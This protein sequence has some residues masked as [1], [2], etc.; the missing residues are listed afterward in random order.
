ME[1]H[2]LSAEKP[3]SKEELIRTLIEN[4]G[5]SDLQEFLHPTSPLNL[6]LQDVGI[7]PKQVT[8]A[9]TRL[10][11]AKEKKE[12]IVIYG[13]YDCDGVCATTVLWETMFSLGFNVTPFI[14]ERDKHGYGLSQKGIDEILQKGKPD[15][16]ISVDNGIVAHGPWQ[17]L[18][19]LGVFTILSDHH[20]PDEKKSPAD[21]IVHTTKLCGTTVSWMLAREIE[22]VCTP[23]THTGKVDLLLDLCAIATIADQVP[24]TE[25]NRSFALFGLQQLNQTK[26]LGLQLL[27]ESS[28]LTPGEI[29]EWGVNY[30]IAPRINAMGRLQSALD[31]LRLLCTHKVERARELVNTVQDVNRTRQELTEELLQKA[32]SRANEWKDEHIIIIDD[33]DFHEGVIGLIAGK[34]TEVFFKPA[35]ALS[36]GKISSKGSARSVTGIHITNLLRTVRDEFQMEVGGHPLAAGLKI[37]TAKIELFKKRLYA[38]AKETIKLEELTPRIDVDCVL[39]SALMTLPTAESLQSLAPFGSANRQPLF[40]FEH[41]KVINAKVIGKEGKHLKITFDPGIEAIAFG[42]GNRIAEFGL[43]QSLSLLG[44]LSVNE[45]KGK[46]SLQIMVKDIRT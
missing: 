39:P 10:Q 19:T 33:V 42:K 27:I 22:K 5:I 17:S 44:N 46:K 4:R 6:T 9:I 24:L 14:P 34:L 8:K 37:E 25:A 16:V 15:I 31:A 32:L 35:I 41:M 30:G 3:E 43:D 20:E 11:I 29:D 2:I 36:V 26:R 18:K 38:I 13:D 12:K 1:W 7:D 21:C 28:G 45:W 23:N 40:V